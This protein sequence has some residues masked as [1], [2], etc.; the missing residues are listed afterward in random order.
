MKLHY[1][2]GLSPLGHRPSQP[3]RPSPT[4]PL[5]PR[6][7]QGNPQGARPERW[8]VRWGTRFGH[9]RRRRLTRGWFPWGRG[10]IG[11]EWRWGAASSGAGRRLMVR[12]GGRDM[13]GRWGGVDGAHRWPEA[14]RRWSAMARHGV[15]SRGVGAGEMAR[16]GVGVG[17]NSSTATTANG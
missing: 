16:G 1:W 12:E 10:S 8:L 6:P 11:G 13:G 5:S 15:G 4:G 14:A 3:W 2:N 9:Q 7:R 17:G